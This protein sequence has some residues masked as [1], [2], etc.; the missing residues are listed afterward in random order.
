MKHA[1]GL[2]LIVVVWLIGA[3]SVSGPARLVRAAL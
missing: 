1:I 2:A 3:V